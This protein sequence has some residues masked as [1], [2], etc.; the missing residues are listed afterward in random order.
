M[1]L[2]SSGNV[3]VQGN[4]YG[5]FKTWFLKTNVPKFFKETW[6]VE[7]LEMLPLKI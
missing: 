2:N 7:K 6:I 4:T 3:V 1:S 5:Q